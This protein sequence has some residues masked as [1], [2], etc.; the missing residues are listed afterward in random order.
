MKSHK[1]QSYQKCR[2]CG[3]SIPAGFTNCDDCYHK[4]DQ[5]RLETVNIP[6]PFPMPEN[7]KPVLLPVRKPVKF[8]KFP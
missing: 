2:V 7:P 3:A 5:A 4:T 8:M 6:V 1:I